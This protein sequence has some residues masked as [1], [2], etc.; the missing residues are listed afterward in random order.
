[1]GNLKRVKHARAFAW[2]FD[3]L[4]AKDV[5]AGSGDALRN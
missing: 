2:Q 5:A 3:V 1:M 4:E